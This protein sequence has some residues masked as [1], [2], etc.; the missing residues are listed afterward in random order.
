MKAI[1]ILGLAV[2]ITLGAWWAWNRSMIVRRYRVKGLWEEMR[3]VFTQ[4]LG[5][6]IPRDQAVSRMA[7]LLL[8]NHRLPVALE[9]GPD[10]FHDL[11]PA[12]FRGDRRIGDLQNR[13]AELFRELQSGTSAA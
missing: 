9:T 13:A 2:A 1:A 10:D 8:A 11:A 12:Q 6:Q 3:Q 5:D 7:T 4:Y